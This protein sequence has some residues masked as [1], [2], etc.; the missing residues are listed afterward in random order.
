MNN[1]FIFAAKNKI[2]FAYNGKITVE[3][4]W[5]LSLEDLD[6]LYR[7]LKREQSMRSE[8]SLLDAPKKE[9]EVL[10]A[11][12]EIVKAVVEDR[13][14]DMTSSKERMARNQRNQKILEIIAKKKDAALESMSIEDLESLLAD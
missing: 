12:I 1:I 7:T 2:R 9:D 13:I 8:D 6:N 14:A 3:D 4:L 11:Q 5:D 10:N